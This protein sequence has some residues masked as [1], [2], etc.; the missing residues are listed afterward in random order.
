MDGKEETAVA[1][2]VVVGLVS[3]VLLEGRDGESCCS[4]GRG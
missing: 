1:V 3:D 4:W 2:V